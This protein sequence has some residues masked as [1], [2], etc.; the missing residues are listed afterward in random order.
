M[1]LCNAS[2]LLPLT[3]MAY[4]LKYGEGKV[5]APYHHNS[6]VSGRI[7]L[8]VISAKKKKKKKTNTNTCKIYTLNK[9]FHKHI[10]T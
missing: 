4:S 3:Q 7:I 1:I 8:N 5:L 6:Q 9:Y 2:I 10:E